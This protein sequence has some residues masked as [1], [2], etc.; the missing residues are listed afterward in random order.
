ME[1]PYANEI[2]YFGGPFGE[3]VDYQ[4]R[5][6]RYWQACVR[7]LGYRR[8]ILAKPESSL[9]QD[10]ASLIFVFCAA[11]SDFGKT[12]LTSTIKSPFSPGFLLIGMPNPGNLS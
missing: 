11:V 2:V 5:W 9:T 7:A 4:G 12:T 10:R 1:H 3:G 8:V 6:Q